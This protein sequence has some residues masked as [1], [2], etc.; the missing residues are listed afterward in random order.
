MENE[1]LSNA[2][3]H[4]RTD[5]VPLHFDT[6]QPAQKPSHT[7]LR[8]FLEAMAFIAVVVTISVVAAI[9]NR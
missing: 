2:F 4:R 9:S 1:H 6:A 5:F 8:V 3:G 7:P